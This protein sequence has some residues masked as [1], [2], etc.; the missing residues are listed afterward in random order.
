[1]DRVGYDAFI[2]YNHDADAQEVGSFFGSVEER[3]LIYGAGSMLR[4]FS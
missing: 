3:G 4:L 2:S 1:M